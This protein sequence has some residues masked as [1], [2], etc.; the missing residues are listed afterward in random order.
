M[1]N[2]AKERITNNDGWEIEGMD[3]EDT[4]EIQKADK[5]IRSS[6]FSYNKKVF[7]LDNNEQK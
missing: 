1:K 3:F 2:E 5:G 7:E 6:S 4:G